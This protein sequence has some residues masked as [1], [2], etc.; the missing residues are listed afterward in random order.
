MRVL[1]APDKFRGTLSAAQ[2]AAAIATGWRRSRPQDVLEE[3]PLADGGDGTMETLVG[4]LGGRRLTSRVSG[5]LGDPVDAAFGLAPVEGGMLGIVEMA[6]ASGLVAVAEGRRDPLRASTRGTGELI[7]AAAREGAR[8]VLMCL[9][10]SATTDGG[11]GAMASLGVKFLDAAGE[12][13]RPGGVGLLDLARIDA[14]SL[15]PA[16]QD[17]EVQAACDVDNPLTGPN[18]AAHVFGPQK[19]ATPQDV[20]LLDRALGHLA[21]VMHRDLGIDVR[22]IP[23]TGAAGGLGVGLVAFFG[24]RLR[25]GFEIVSDA[26][27]LVAR[28][29][30]SDLV[31]TG[32]GAFDA[33]SY[34]GKVPIGVLEVARAVGIPGI[35][36]CGHAEIR[37]EGVRIGSLTERF[38]AE[39]ALSDAR[40]ALEDLAAELA[41]GLEPVG[42][43]G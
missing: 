30:R 40:S 20:V 1:V 13:I 16:V 38:G 42:S 31:I 39:R 11:A 33:S 3:L 5:P 4:A 22:A 27:G 26:V 8:A 17:L 43:G 37:P 10:G 19:G 29:E 6:L 23:G 2:A 7:L 32:E 28:L 14:S 25:P 9:G 36:L 24:A 21:A 41:A 12:P 18:G 35:V 15:D 34:R